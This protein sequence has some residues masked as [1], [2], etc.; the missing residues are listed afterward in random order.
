MSAWSRFVPRISKMKWIVPRTPSGSMECPALPCPALSITYVQQAYNNKCRNQM[1]L[2]TTRCLGCQLNF[3][4]GEMS[5]PESCPDIPILKINDSKN[6]V[7]F[8]PLLPFPGH[9]VLQVWARSILYQSSFSPTTTAFNQQWDF[10]KVVG[11]PQS[12]F[13]HNSP[14]NFRA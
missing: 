1:K 5:Y 14:Q 3:L 10:C 11:P 13:C 7:V 4:N 9:K 8:D 6:K 2:H 12:W